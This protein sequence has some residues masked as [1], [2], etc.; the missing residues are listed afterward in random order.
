MYYFFLCRMSDSD[1]VVLICPICLDVAANPHRV[2]PCSHLFCA[3]CLISVAKVEGKH[4][5]RCPLCR[6]KITE[7]RKY[8]GKFT[9]QL[10]TRQSNSACVVSAM[11]THMHSA[12]GTVAITTP[13]SLPSA[14][15][16]IFGLLHTICLVLLRMFYLIAIGAAF[17]LIILPTLRL[18]AVLIVAALFPDECI[19]PFEIH[20]YV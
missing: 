6:R 18:V 17:Y 14:K 12:G 10:I 7:C 11:S 13:H 8:P 19:L 9:K 16:R 20:R 3:S 5:S 4:T 2:L 15:P 1:D